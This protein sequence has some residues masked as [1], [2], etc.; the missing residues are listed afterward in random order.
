MSVAQWSKYT[1]LKQRYCYTSILSIKIKIKTVICDKKR[2]NWW[3][4]CFLSCRYRAC[5]TIV[6]ACCISL[7]MCS[8]VTF[9]LWLTTWWWACLSSL[10]T[11]CFNFRSRHLVRL[12]C[13]NKSWNMVLCPQASHVTDLKLH[14]AICLFR[15]RRR[16]FF[17]HPLLSFGQETG[18]KGQS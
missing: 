12:W 4:F 6:L 7:R 9:D 8:L 5:S 11:C 18:A 14:S 17:L 1:K 16:T 10:I 2:S 13:V 15:S 3:S